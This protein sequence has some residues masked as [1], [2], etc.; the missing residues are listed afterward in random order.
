MLASSS[1]VCLEVKQTWSP[2]HFTPMHG[3]IMRF[4][5]TISSMMTLNKCWLLLSPLMFLS[6]CWSSVYVQQQ[7][8]AL[9]GIVLQMPDDFHQWYMLAPDRD[10][11]FETGCDRFWGR[12]IEGPVLCYPGIGVDYRVITPGFS[13]DEEAVEEALEPHFISQYGTKL[14][15][16]RKE[17]LDHAGLVGI[18][19]V[20]ERYRF[21]QGT[22]PASRVATYQEG[23]VFKHPYNDRLLIK[24]FYEEISSDDLGV[25]QS[26]TTR[27]SAR[28]ILTNF[29]VVKFAS[30]WSLTSCM[31]WADSN[32]IKRAES[33]LKTGR[34][35][36]AIL[37]TKQLLNFLDDGKTHPK[38]VGDCYLLLAKCYR[39]NDDFE[40]ARKCL[41]LA[42]RFYTEASYPL[43]IS[44]SL[45]EEATLANEQ[46]GGDE[47][48]QL[49]RSALKFYEQAMLEDASQSVPIF[50]SD[51]DNY[52]A[53][54]QRAL[55][56]LNCE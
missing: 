15:Y 2:Q 25:S 20:W 44:C 56:E 19:Y 51:I 28:Y 23:I 22:E 34:M 12:E 47:A 32:S 33:L 46:I 21:D 39:L 54:I 8:I 35:Y 16:F 38:Q 48:C 27:V 30:T 31:G 6:G 10:P 41:T 4:H 13:W 14:Q 37:Q 29:L 1:E 50:V 45:V 40:T 3:F 53:Y 43:G 5:P 26:P 18:S 24:I 49:L 17:I 7:N 36:A 52:G 9:P 11:G 42:K 55:V